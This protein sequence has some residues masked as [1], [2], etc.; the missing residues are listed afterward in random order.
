MDE[1]LL[2]FDNDKTYVFIDCETENLCLNGVHNLP[3]QIAMLK[4]K[5]SRK[6]DEKNYFVSWGRELSVSKEAAKIT[7]FNP[8]SHRKKA[9]PFED[10]FP[11][12]NDWL[13]NCDYIVGHNLLGFDIYLIKD[14]YNHEGKS[15]HFLMNKIVDT[16]CIA[17]G[18]QMGVKYKPSESF[19]EYQYKILNTKKRG[20]RTRLVTLGKNYD[21]PHDYDKLHDAI[22]DLELNLKVWNKLKYQIE[23]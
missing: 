1:H 20:L 14:F 6:I 5:N 7:R 3:W 21:I 18:I 8:V 2:R 17:K 16:Y 23:L 11:T 9:V 10:V 4:V 15:Y 22:V 12:I 19:L 13:T